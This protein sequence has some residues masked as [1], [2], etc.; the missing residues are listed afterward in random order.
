M[1]GEEGASRQTSKHILPAVSF[2]SSHS[3][4]FFKATYLL[5]GLRTFCTYRPMQWNGRQ[6]C[7]GTI[8]DLNPALWQME[9]TNQR[10]EFSKRTNQRAGFCKRTN[11]RGGFRKR[12]NQRAGSCKRTNQTG[13]F[14]KR[15][16][17]RGG[18][19]RRTNQ[20]VGFCIRTNQR[21]G[22]CKRTN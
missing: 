15:T 20:R 19:F 7:F 13:G 22:F 5:F 2:L 9:R 11:Q 17:Q 3:I 4:R 10:A 21:A 12:T 6:S 18:F 16:N 14:R 8:H 1:G